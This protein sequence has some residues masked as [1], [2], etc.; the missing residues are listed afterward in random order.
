M[1][2]SSS[3]TLSI[4]YARLFELPLVE[5]KSPAGAFIT[6][7]QGRRVSRPAS[8]RKYFGDALSASADADAAGWPPAS[9][10]K[11]DAMTVGELWRKNGAP[12]ED[13]EVLRLG[14]LGLLGDGIDAISALNG[15]RETA[16]RLPGDQHFRIEGGNDR[17][18]KAF[19]SK[20]RE[21][22]HYGAPV[23]GITHDAAS[24]RVAVK[25]ASG[26]HQVDRGSAG[27]RRAVHD[28]P[29]R[30][31][32]AGVL[33]AEAA[34]DRRG[35]VDGGDAYVSPVPDA[36]LDGRRFVGRRVNG[37]PGRE[38]QSR[39]RRP[40]GTSRHPGVV[41]RRRQRA[42]ARRHAA[43]RSTRVRRRSEQPD[44]SGASLAIRRRDLDQLGHRSVGERRVRLVQAGP[45]G[46]AAA[47]PG[48]G[49]RGAY[50]SRATIRRRCQ[51]GCRA[52]SRPRN[53]SYRRFSMRRCAGAP[54]RAHDDALG[55]RR[56]SV[57]L[58]RLFTPM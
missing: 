14:F 34:G 39:D 2:I 37:S 45:V 40:A 36:L 6:H 11:Y 56:A 19:A 42:Q 38:P 48:S 25:D 57:R 41:C 7:I 52:R 44:L 33:S 58:L 20:L 4:R 31:D 15:L 49:R 46:A 9:L 29:R 17:L 54:T 30:R 55:R 12:E 26:V 13:L 21:R 51:D 27:L 1:T 22:I 5:V 47:A 43:P 16:L 23:V 32:L 8:A 10:E 50:T 53:G 3:H 18:P 35:A 24:V 28:A